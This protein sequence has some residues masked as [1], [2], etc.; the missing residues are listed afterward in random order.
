METFTL[1]AKK[2]TTIGRKTDLLRSE[3]VLPAVVYGS[4][5]EPTSIE[6]RRTEFVK[7]YSEAGESTVITLSVDGSPLNVLVQDIQVHPMRGEVIHADFRA[8]D[9]TQKIE[10]EV[11]IEFVGESKAVETFGGTLV[12]NLDTL[13]VKALPIHLVSSIEVDLSPLVTFDDVILVSSVV[14]PEGIEMM[15]D[16]EELIATVTPPRSDAE[17]EALNEEVVEDLSSIEGVKEKKETDEDEEEE[18]KK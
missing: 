6:L 16:P 9:M 3:G 14:A 13:S 18:E 4:G 12:R 11:K 5:V 1:E 17:M 10:A 8:L 15:N 2:R 7:V